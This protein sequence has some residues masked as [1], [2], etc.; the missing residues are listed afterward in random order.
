MTTEELKRLKALRELEIEEKIEFVV[1][2]WN[3]GG[4]IRRKSRNSFALVVHDVRNRCRFGTAR[5]ILGDLE[6]LEASGRLPEG[7]SFF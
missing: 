5:E 1:R 3:V 4:Y 2:P 7:K 6:R